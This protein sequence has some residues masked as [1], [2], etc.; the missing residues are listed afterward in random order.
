MTATSAATVPAPAATVR[1]RQLWRHA[2]AWQIALAVYMQAI[3]WIPLG[4]WNHQPCCPT[5]LAQLQQGRLDAGEAVGLL[6]FLVPVIVFV[7]AGRYRW[8]WAA[9]LSLAA[10]GIWLAL[11]LWTWWPP[12]VVGASDRWARVY[13]RAF[14]EATQVLPRWGDH[15]PPDAMHLVL[16]ALLTGVLISGMRA[17]RQRFFSVTVP[18]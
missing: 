11:Q 9:C 8:R 16:Q 12:Y 4:R 17:V 3:S 6:A 14:A 15:L 13:A 5:G 1:H 18:R 10:Y 7:A 2:V